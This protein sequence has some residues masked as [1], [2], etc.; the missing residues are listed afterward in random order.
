[1]DTPEHHD[2]GEEVLAGLLAAARSSRLIAGMLQ[3]A[4]TATVLEEVSAAQ[5]A[6]ALGLTGVTVSILA[7]DGSSERVW[8]A[9]DDRIGPAVDDVEYIVGEGPAHDAAR[10]GQAV[11]EPNLSAGPADHWPLFRPDAVRCGAAALFTFPI[12]LGNK[13]LGVLNGYRVTPG[14]LTSQQRTAAWSLTHAAC[15]LLLQLQPTTG[16]SGAAP[17]A[18]CPAPHRDQVHQAAG[19]LSVKLEI[20]VAKALERLRAHAYGQDRPLLDLAREIVSRHTDP[21]YRLPD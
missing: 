10:S 12:L 20:P 14:P 17:S 8:A 21:S 7:T 4:G 1:M 2:A 11:C 5:C 19:I 18:R 6:A 16:I 13:V 3:S 9:P 15:L